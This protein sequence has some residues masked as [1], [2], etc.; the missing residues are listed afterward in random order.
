MSP[1]RENDLRSLWRGR[2]RN[3]FLH[4]S[5]VVLAIFTLYSWLGPT[6]DPVSF[7]SSSR[8][9]NLGHFI[10]EE[11]V[12]NPLRG[13]TFDLS[14]LFLW[15]KTL[16]LT[17]G[18]EATWRTLAISILAIVLAGSLSLLLAP[19]AA[20]NVATALPFQQGG[21]R[22]P[23][24]R[25]ISWRVGRWLT[26]ALFILLRALPE[27]L[28]A[29]LLLAMLGPR[30]AWPAVLALALH[31][32]GILGRLNSETMENLDPAPLTSLNGLGARRSSVVVAAVYPLALGR[33]LLYFFYRFETCV[34]EAT[35]LGM[36]GILSLGYWIQ[37]ARA[38]HFYDEMFLFVLLGVSI[39]FFA[40]ICSALARR[41]I[42]SS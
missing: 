24:F 40:D 32:M 5:L 15:A 3:H 30:T 13:K 33:F 16:I 38:K 29:F 19:F 14:E 8:A 36:L 11:L 4:W 37:D 35:V 28:V 17:K 31:N 1:A 10:T 39:V 42:R 27:Y 41:F 34:R 18:L 9:S 22:R 12:P 7:F 26:A 23:A 2:E 20:R 21:Y 25:H 6:I